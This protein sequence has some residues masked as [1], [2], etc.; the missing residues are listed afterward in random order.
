M[1]GSDSIAGSGTAI[2]TD[3]TS[4]TIGL[5]L[6]AVTRP[7]KPKKER[8]PHKLITCVYSLSS[9][10]G[11]LIGLQVESTKYIKEIHTS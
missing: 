6:V 2:R 7:F 11:A 9:G 5:L 8:R 3:V 4:P 10:T 1:K